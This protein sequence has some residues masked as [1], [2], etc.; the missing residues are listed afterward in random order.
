[1]TA[2]GSW[3][4]LEEVAGWRRDMIFRGFAAVPP[5]WQKLC[6]WLKNATQNVKHHVFPIEIHPPA[7]S[8]CFVT[9]N[10]WV[11]T[12]VQFRIP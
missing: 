12:G 9:K 7:L 5:I 8:I 11:F 6:P 2:R 4:L 1:M 10:R 3:H